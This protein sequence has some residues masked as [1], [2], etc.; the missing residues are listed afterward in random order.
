VPV[1]LGRQLLREKRDDPAHVERLLALR[2]ADARD[3]LLHRGGVH[4]GVALEQL[5]HDERAHVVGAQRR[6]RALE[7]AADGGAEGVDDHCF[8]HLEGLL[9]SGGG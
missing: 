4:V 6:E 1:D 7:G 2:K 8:G 5:V 9:V 3:H